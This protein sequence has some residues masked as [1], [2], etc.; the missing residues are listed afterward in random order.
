[1]LTYF[2]NIPDSAAHA[3]AAAALGGIP[4]LESTAEMDWSE[5][6]EALVTGSLDADILCLPVAN[7]DLP[8]LFK[9]GY[10]AP[11]TG[12]KIISDAVAALYPFLQDAL[13][14]NG[15]AY[16]FPV[17]CWVYGPGAYGEKF[18]GLGLP[19]PKT[20]DELIAL[21]QKWGDDRLYEAYADHQ[22]FLWTGGYRQKLRS[23]ALDMWG[24]ALTAAGKEW[25]LDDPALRAL[26]EKIDRLDTGDWKVTVDW[27]NDPNA[28]ELEEELF[29]RDMLLEQAMEYALPGC[30]DAKLLPLSFAE[31]M[32]ADVG[33][34]LY[35]LA[36]NARSPHQEAALRYIENY[37]A[38]MEPLTLAA[39]RAD[40]NTPISN[41]DL[42][43]REAVS[44]WEI[45]RIQKALETAEAV[46]VPQLEQ[47]LT[48]WQ[49]SLA[50]LRSHPDLV[51]AED[52][53]A[54]KERMANAFV[55]RPSLFYTDL[56]PDG[57]LKRLLEQYQDGLI[58]LD[59]FLSQG[60]ETLRLILMENK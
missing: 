12:S 49:E 19:A 30:A 2:G 22:L 25:T 51:T 7:V 6:T 21:V 3:K 26:L 34:D 31:N 59:Q 36:V 5:M 47:E 33:V 8:A 44:I 46:D 9:K 11:L 60:Q 50:D 29:D 37:I 56:N 18:E 58:A 1:M 54:W 48:A 24:D 53:S 42:A 15:T 43:E 35:V 14:E 57:S 13:T 55:K 10:C 32:P 4:V 16:A 17:S 38:A 23:L 39:M 45:E 52:L 28:A 20:L 40:W 27:E 41:P